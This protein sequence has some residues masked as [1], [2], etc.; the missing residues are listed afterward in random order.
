MTFRWYFN[1]IIFAHSWKDDIDL[2]FEILSAFFK[3][4]PP[5]QLYYDADVYELE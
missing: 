3:I 5:P 1:N 2:L 4:Q